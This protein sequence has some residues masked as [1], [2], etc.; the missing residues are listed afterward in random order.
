[1]NIIQLT[2]AAAMIL[3]LLSKEIRLW[4]QLLTKK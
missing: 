2:L 3:I 4:Y 1:M